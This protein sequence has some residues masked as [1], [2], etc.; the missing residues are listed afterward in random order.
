ML[1]PSRRFL[2]ESGD[3]RH[4]LT[5]VNGLPSTYSGSLTILLN[6]I[7]PS[8]VWRN[9]LFLLILGNIPDEV[10]AADMALHFWYSAF[11]PKE[12]FFQISAVLAKFLQQTKEGKIVVPLGPCST[13]SSY[14]PKD[15]I[16]FFLH[17]IS[18]SIS[19]GDAQEEYDHVRNA[20]E[21]RDFKDRMY[22]RLNTSHRVAFQEYRRFRIILPFGAARILTAQTFPFFHPRESGCKR[23]MQTH[24]EVGSKFIRSLRL[25][26][27]LRYP[28]CQCRRSNREAAWSPPGGHLRVSLLFPLGT[29]ADVRATDLQD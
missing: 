27:L 21:R 10:V 23:T 24:S 20:P 16:D 15:A 18:T 1:V 25:I 11:M 26:I 6:D 3:L 22:A 13:L 4:V 2:V 12:Y 9:I 7:N 29:T 28:K 8:V 14:L 17:C 19:I 5:T